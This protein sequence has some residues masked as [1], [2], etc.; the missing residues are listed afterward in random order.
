MELCEIFSLKNVMIILLR[1]VLW[2]QQFKEY[3][4]SSYEESKYNQAE[5]QE[6]RVNEKEEEEEE[7]EELW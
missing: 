6:E 7:E 4:K 2:S 1:S 3:S 5:K